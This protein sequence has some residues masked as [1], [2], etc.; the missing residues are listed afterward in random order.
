MPPEGL[1]FNTTGNLTTLALILAWDD[2]NQ[3]LEPFLQSSKWQCTDQGSGP[4]TDLGET[5]QCQSDS[6]VRYPRD[7]E[8]RGGKSLDDGSVALILGQEDLTEVLARCLPVCQWK[9][10]PEGSFAGVPP[11]VKVKS[12][13]TA[14]AFYD[15]DPDSDLPDLGNYTTRP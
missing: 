8:F 2:P 9:A 13:L 14:V 11:T 15:L 7:G 10:W 12:A 5:V 1:L 4:F 6:L 3:S